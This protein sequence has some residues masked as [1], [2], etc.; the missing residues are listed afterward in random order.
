MSDKKKRMRRLGA[1]IGVGAAVTAALLTL[2]LLSFA[3]HIGQASTTAAPEWLRPVTR[4]LDQRG[5]KWIDIDVADGV[6]TVSGEAPDVDSRRFGFEAAETAIQTAAPD[7]ALVVDATQLTGG[8]A[9][10]GAALKALGATPAAVDCQ[11]AFQGVLSGRT[12]N[13]APG[14]A[15]LTPDNKRLLDALSA[16]A[17]R[18]RAFSIEVGGH[19]DTSGSP[20]INRTLS[21]SRAQAVAAYLTSKGAPTEALTARGFGSSRPLDQSRGPEADARNRRIEFTVAAR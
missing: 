12:I 1:G 5:F 17:I 6:A 7:L 4:D 21:Q 9:S 14:S 20:G 11:T 15:D 19:T 8:E 13:F 10:V 2:G 16:V 18:C 3:G